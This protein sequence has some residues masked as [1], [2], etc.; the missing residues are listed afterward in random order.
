MPIRI[1]CPGCSVELNAPDTSAGKKVRCPKPECG[2]VASVPGKAAVK[3]KPVLVPV[4]VPVPS[5]VPVK[6]A[7]PVP[8]R[9]RL[10]VPA[11]VVVAAPIAASAPT[12]DTGEHVPDDEGAEAR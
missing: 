9:S 12:V 1:V 4:T 7:I 2:A 5:P 8:A 3:L 11:R 10:P 6:A